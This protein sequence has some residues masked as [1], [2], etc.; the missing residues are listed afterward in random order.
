MMAQLESALVGGVLFAFPSFVKKTFAAMPE[1]KD[2]AT[3]QTMY[4]VVIS[5][6]FI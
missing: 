6:L 1:S 3:M 5:A 4:A 2:V